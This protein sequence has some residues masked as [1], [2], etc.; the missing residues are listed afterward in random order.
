MNDTEREWLQQYKHFAPEKILSEFLPLLG[1]AWETKKA[2]FTSEDDEIKVT[3]ALCAFITRKTR[4]PSMSTAWGIHYEAPQLEELENGAGHVI[5]RCDLTISVASQVYICECKCIKQ[6]VSSLFTDS[7]R[8]YVQQGVLRFLQPSNSQTTIEPQYSTW[9]GFAGMI[10]YVMSGAVA[11]ARDALITAL[12]KHAPPLS[13]SRPHPPTCPAQDA[14]HFLT[15][16]KNNVQQ[17]VNMHHV[18]LSLP[19]RGEGM[20]APSSQNG[21]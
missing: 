7:A 4:H 3:K 5:G 18:V 9:L 14:E 21:Q 19:D 17:C 1:E 10:G 15:V 13:I 11:G 8:L 6:S 16:H 12:T 2:I 20:L